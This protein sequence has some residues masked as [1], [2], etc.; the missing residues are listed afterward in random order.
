MDKAQLERDAAGLVGQIIFCLSR[1]EFNLGLYLRNAVGGRDVEAVNPLI[2]RLSFKAKI[3]ALRDVV[4][5]E[6]CSEEACISEF[7]SW[8]AVMD[9]FR[10]KRNSFVHGRWAMVGPH[11][12]NA[13]SVLPGSNAQKETRYLVADLATELQKAEEISASFNRWSDRWP[14]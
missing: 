14:L 10:P 13:A 11:A 5:R 1:L 4:G 6:F 7:R 9:E 3:D 2:E 8:W 12:I